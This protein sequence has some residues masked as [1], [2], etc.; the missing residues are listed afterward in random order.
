VR[1]LRKCCLPLLLSWLSSGQLCLSLVIFLRME[2]AHTDILEL[3][4]GVIVLGLLRVELPHMFLMAVFVNESACRV[5][6]A[7]PLLQ[8]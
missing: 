7:L 6:E 3:R 2:Q 4:L 1:V 8:V 5:G